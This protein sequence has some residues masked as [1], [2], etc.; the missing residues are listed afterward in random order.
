MKTRRLVLAALSAILLASLL[1]NIVLFRTAKSFYVRL[2]TVRLDPMG[3]RAR[4]NSTLDEA[5]HGTRVLL[6]GDSRAEQW[7]NADGLD[8]FRFINHGVGGLTTAQLLGRL[9]EDL[10]STKPDIVIL[11]AGVNDL[12]T[13]PLFPQRRDDIIANCK[14]NLEAIVT[15]CETVKS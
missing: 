4:H 12:K 1:L 7:T 10:R 6:V 11:Q 14:T 5:F 8:D 13:L 2:H 15:Q 9:H 3:S